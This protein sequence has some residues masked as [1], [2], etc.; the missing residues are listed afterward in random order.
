MQAS[1]VWKSVVGYEGLYEVSNLGRIK[2]RR[3]TVV[4]KQGW[5]QTV[6][7]QVCKQKDTHDGYKEVTLCKNSERKCIRVHRLV[8][9]AFLGAPTDSKTEVNHMDGNK[10]N[11]NVSNLEWVTSS[12][13]QL[14]AYR[15]GLQTVSGNAVLGKKDIVCIS[16]NH[17]E[18]GYAN[19]LRYLKSK[20]YTKTDSLNWLSHLANQSETFCYLGLWF[21]TKRKDIEK[22]KQ[23]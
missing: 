21:S 20:G 18:H 10:K 17:Y 11:N 9:Y 12:E 22:C 3:R 5:I 2:S 6:H 14:H 16:L 7:G 13:N 4:T 23:V 8:A 1:E 19:M 15:T